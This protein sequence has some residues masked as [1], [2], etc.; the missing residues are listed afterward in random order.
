MDLRVPRRP[1]GARPERPERRGQ[2]GRARDAGLLVLWPRPAATSPPRAGSRV[3]LTEQVFAVIGD[4][5]S[6][7]QNL[8]T[9]SSFV[10]QVREILDVAGPGSLVLLDELGAGTDPAEGAALGAALLEA[11]LARGARVVATTH[12]E[13]LK[14]FAQRPRPR[15]RRSRST[16]TA[17][18]DV[19]PRVRASRPEPRPH[20]RRRG[21]ACPRG[22][23]AGARPRRGEAGGSRPS[24][25]T[26][27]RARGRAAASPPARE[28]ES[29]EALR[30]PGADGGRR[31]RSARIRRAREARRPS[32]ARR[33][34][35]RASVRTDRLKTDEAAGGG[36]RRTPIAASAR[37]R[38]R[39]GRSQPPGENPAAPG[40]VRVRG[41][42]VRG[43]V[44]GE[45]DGLVTVQAGRLTLK[46]A[47]SEIEAAADGAARPAPGTVSVPVREDVPRSSA[48][49]AARRTRRGWRSRSSS[50]TPRS[51]DTGRSGW[52]TARAREPSGAPWRACSGPPPGQCVPPRRAGRGRGGR[53][54][55]ALEGGDDTGAR[56][57]PRPLPNRRANR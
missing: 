17:R 25:P 49:S 12:L 1:A 4:E 18:A 23:R 40:E 26:L 32:V 16:P 38:G 42:G 51:P 14:V 6:L 5:Q 55:V 57:A 47:R 20:D 50:T 13:P 11:L 34:P 19:P 31:G 35:S 21:S 9:F 15:T 43:R 8:S 37:P 54:V 10:R 44:V 56:A 29:A 45:A 39:S 24:W 27:R 22:H 41:L 48:C 28:A 7:A 36:K 2:D 46:V 30:A 33:H 53:T 52:S 3:P